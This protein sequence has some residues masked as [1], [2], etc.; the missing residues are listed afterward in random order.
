[1]KI[2]FDWKNFRK[3]KPNIGDDIII[4]VF[5]E[6]SMRLKGESDY[7]LIIGKY[8]DFENGRHWIFGSVINTN[9]CNKKKILARPFKE[10][11]NSV[12][13]PINPDELN[14][15]WDFYNPNWI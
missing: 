6:P 4:K 2:I 10:K 13:N 9:K 14:F 3:I 8:E 1:M 12:I 11:G 5:V 7:I 15:D